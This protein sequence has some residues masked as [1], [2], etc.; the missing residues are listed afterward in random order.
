[1]KQS[2]FHISYLFVS[3]VLFPRRLFRSHCDMIRVFFQNI[4][5]FDF[6]VSGPA[7]ARA[8][9]VWLQSRSSWVYQL[10]RGGSARSDPGCLLSPE[11]HFAPGTQMA[12]TSQVHSYFDNFC[13]TI[14]YF[15]K[16]CSLNI[17][18]FGIARYH[19]LSSSYKPWSRNVYGHYINLNPWNI[20]L[21]FHLFRHLLF[22]PL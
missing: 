1:M 5:R 13:I 2:I 19:Y 16:P 18:F 21:K 15:P 22:K 14:D 6:V 8:R 10:G 12:H 4:Y 17:H 11:S 9:H 3:E 20:N 7:Q